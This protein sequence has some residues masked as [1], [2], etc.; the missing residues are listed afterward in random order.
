MTL[1]W[2]LV[3]VGAALVIAFGV[4]SWRNRQPALP[5]TVPANDDLRQLGLSEV[6]P[7]QPGSRSV[8]TPAPEE[9]RVPDPAPLPDRLRDYGAPHVPGEPEDA[10]QALLRAVRVAL[11]A[12][13]V[14]LLE[15][16][17]RRFV[18]E[19][20]SGQRRGL[21]RQRRVDLSDDLVGAGPVVLNGRALS[22][23]DLGGGGSALVLTLRAE[24]PEALLIV[25][26]E[27]P[28]TEESAGQAVALS[29]AVVMLRYGEAEPVALEVRG[30]RVPQEE[31]VA[32]VATEGSAAQASPEP[33]S[34]PVLD[35]VPDSPTDA[36]DDEPE[37]ALA[38]LDGAFDDPADSIALGETVSAPRPVRRSSEP[39]EEEP[40][41]PRSRTE[42][43][44]EEMEAARA[45]GEPLT[46]ALVYR[47]D[48]EEVAAHSEAAVADSEAALV[49]VLRQLSG[50][51]RVER[52]GELTFG[53]FLR[54]GA[55]EAI[56][57]SERVQSEI[58]WPLLIGAAQLNDR[59]A[60]PA[61]LRADA[62]EALHLAYA[63][64]PPSVVLS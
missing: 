26:T 39:V 10:L 40:A 11:G 9:V 16:R 57:W 47:A 4:L 25:A 20:V 15:R 17:R 32:E 3:V 37:T 22:A 28:V 58:A 55:T 29:E 23:V 34:E 41:A 7:A 38:D 49:N 6:R 62:T 61:E 36:P 13:A 21:V 33:T 46:L 56:A 27:E 51:A 59:H 42:I 64:G 43:V 60:S 54:R 35:A 1:P 45:A 30:E 48:A 31:L 2:L 12:E 52:F 50:G 24:E 53:V 8:S 44:G 5:R 18:V 19:A 14:A 63:D